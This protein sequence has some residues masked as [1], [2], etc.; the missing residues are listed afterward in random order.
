MYSLAPQGLGESSA[1]G[2]RKLLRRLSLD[3]WSELAPDTSARRR[4]PVG[5]ASYFLSSHE[6][7]LKYTLALFSAQVWASHES[8]VGVIDWYK[9]SAFGAAE[10]APRF[11]SS[12][13]DL[14][15]VLSATTNN[16]LAAL[17]PGN[18]TVG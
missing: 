3:D 5:V 1:R 12:G 17:H 6:M 9:S 16:V 2:G 18:G 4:D 14:S 8:D 11:H 13:N 7:R 15:L 10:T